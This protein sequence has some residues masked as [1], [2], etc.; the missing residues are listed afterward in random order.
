MANDKRELE[1][2]GF[3]KLQEMIYI[4]YN[5]FPNEFKGKYYRGKKNRQQI[6]GFMETINPDYC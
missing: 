2:G 5:S 6:R 4:R 3:V 1:V